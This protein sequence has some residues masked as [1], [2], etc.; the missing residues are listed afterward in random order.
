MNPISKLYNK[1]LA[2][3]EV[4]IQERDFTLEA[5]G[6]DENF[7]NSGVIFFRKSPAAAALFKAW[8]DEWP[9]FAQWDEQLALTR[10]IY[11]VPDL[12]VK[13]LGMDW[14]HPHRDKSR[15]VVIFHN[16][17]RGDVRTNVSEK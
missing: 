13:R 5:I 8:Q 6:H 7:L 9:R 17:G 15:T 10:A 14:N 16:Y 3:W 2:G 1:A 12:N 4:N 11:Q